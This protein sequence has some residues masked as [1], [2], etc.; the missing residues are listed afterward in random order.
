MM[1]DA[2]DRDF[3][4]FRGT[5]TRDIYDNIRTAVDTVF[6]G[7]ERVFILGRLDRWQVVPV[8]NLT[9]SSSNLITLRTDLDLRML[10]PPIRIRSRTRSLG[11]VRI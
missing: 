3:A 8:L 10:E 6:L 4:F 1:F 11:M 9:G 7:R 5:C 2:H